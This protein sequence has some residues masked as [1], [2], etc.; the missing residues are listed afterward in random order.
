MNRVNRRNR[1]RRR[2]AGITLIELIVAV[3]LIG[4]MTLAVTAAFTAGLDMERAQM[5]RQGTQEQL[6]A[7]ERKITRLL[8]GAR[9]SEL[10][11]DTA[12]YFKNDTTTSSGSEDLGAERITFTTIAPGI[13]LSA[14]HSQDDFETQQQNNQGPIAGTAEVSLGTTAVGDAGDHK[15][16]FERLQ[17]PS[18]GDATQGGTETTL[19]PLIN[20]MGFQFWDGT[21]WVTT[22]DTT[23][24]PYTGHLPAAVLVSY[25]VLNDSQSTVH[26]FT[27]PIPTSDVTPENPVSAE[28]SS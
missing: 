26:S 12:T 22:W 18:D 24:S 10:T 8:Q 27:V 15:G 23:T 2:S 16:L 7:M 1:T 13:P 28:G 5:R 25:T 9:L 6:E 3:A 11:T 20:Q 4:I 17:V 19:C 14:I 21:Q